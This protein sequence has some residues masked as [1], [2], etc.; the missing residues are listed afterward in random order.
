MLDVLALSLVAGAGAFLVALGLAAFLRP[1]RV[2]AFLL[3]FAG[4]PTRHFAELLVRLAVGAALVL[5][6]PGLAAGTVFWV[7]GWVLIATTAILL[8]VP[9][10]THRAFAQ[11]TVPQALRHLPVI[12]LA[13]LAAGGGTLCAVVGVGA[14][15]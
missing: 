11:A 13:S 14:C 7:F 1:Q 15:S 3:G 9:W 12:G 8:V 6:A 4:S 5:A 2:R 10:R